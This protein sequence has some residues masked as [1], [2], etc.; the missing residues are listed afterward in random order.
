M[1][2]A[3]ASAENEQLFLATVDRIND[4]VFGQ[5]PADSITSVHEERLTNFLSF[6]IEI[7]PAT[8]SSPAPKS[9]IVPGSGTASG[10]LI[11]N[12]E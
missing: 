7:T 4:D 8:P 12:S 2:A 11:R 3:M 9:V 6:A 1:F 5:K 10:L